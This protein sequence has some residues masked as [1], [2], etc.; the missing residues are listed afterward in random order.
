MLPFV[1]GLVLFF[2]VH[3]ISIVARDW[4]DRQLASL[5]E[6]AWKGLYTLVSLIGFVLLCYGYGET[7]ATPIVLYAPAPWLRH[8]A[9]LL[10]LPVFPLLLSVYLPGH[11]KA[12]ARHP[13]LLATKIWASAHLLA[14]GTV[15]DVMLFGGFL[16][17][18]VADR[19]AVKRRPQ[20]VVVIGP[21]AL[22]ND[23]IAIVAGTGIYAAF[24]FGLH[25][26]LIGVS[27]L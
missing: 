6:P 24:L 26:W 21:Q 5:G 4:R 20:Q 12:R 7:R 1:T 3:S 17:W 16:A 11:L 14:N 8:L 15:A 10:L 27:P 19:I 25:A 2:G 23:L 13:M 18:A 22:R 9:L